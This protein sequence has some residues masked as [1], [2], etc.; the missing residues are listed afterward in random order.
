M[1]SEPMFTDWLREF[2]SLQSD[3]VVVHSETSLELLRSLST[4]IPPVV[5]WEIV[6]AE[7]F[8][9]EQEALLEAGRSLGSA[10][11]TSAKQP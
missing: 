3:P 11:L 8:V 4:S 7:T 6:S 9:Y 2:V 5:E 10:G 1:T